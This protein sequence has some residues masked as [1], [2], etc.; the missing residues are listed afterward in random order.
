[1]HVRQET[2][3]GNSYRFLTT[4]SVLIRATMKTKYPVADY[5]HKIGIITGDC[6]RIMFAYYGHISNSSAILLQT[7]YVF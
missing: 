7:V 3:H 6:I 4:F 1:M 2:K 5:H